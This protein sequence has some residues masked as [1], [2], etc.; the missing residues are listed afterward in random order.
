[1]VGLSLFHSFFLFW[2]GSRQD[3]VNRTESEGCG[4]PGSLLG[5]NN[6]DMGRIMVEIAE[7]YLVDRRITMEALFRCL[8]AQR[9]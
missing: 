8:L 7:T 1:M 5:S 9:R 4:I 3:G 6:A 2:Y